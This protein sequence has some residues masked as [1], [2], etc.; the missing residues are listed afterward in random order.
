MVGSYP[1]E[2]EKET[3]TMSSD[4]FQ[5]RNISAFEARRHLGDVLE[6]IK[7]SDCRFMIERYGG[8]CAA[9]VTSDDLLVLEALAG[10]SPTSIANMRCDT[11][12]QIIA[13]A[14]ILG[15]RQAQEED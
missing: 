4:G 10:M 14:L 5:A 1:A 13:R 7:D 9:L 3:Q 8:E 15:W 2:E 11:D 12:K 6:E